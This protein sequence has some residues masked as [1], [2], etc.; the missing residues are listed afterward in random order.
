[1]CQEIGHTFGLA[2]QD[3]A[4][5][6]VNLGTCMDYTNNPDGPPANRQ[7]DDHD[8]WM[9]DEIIYAHLDGGGGGGGG[10]GGDKGC[11]GPAWKCG[12]ATPP[13][14]AFDMELADIG[15]WGR[16]LG[17]SRDG[18][19]SIFVQDFGN[20]SRVFTHV[21]WTLEIAEGARCQT[22]SRCDPTQAGLHPRPAPR[23][24]ILASGWLPCATTASAWLRW[25]LWR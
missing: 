13:P 25:R 24:Q 11:K 3:E 16:L 15:Q 7:P 21:T 9:L 17:T 1:M 14:P 6:N 4:F 8:S 2:H 22:L 12:G 5:E 18:G 20:G 19:Q 23:P 10:G